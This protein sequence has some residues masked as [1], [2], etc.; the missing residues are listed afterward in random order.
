MKEGDASL[1]ESIA[2]E[3]KSLNQ[4]W[5]R[6]VVL[7]EEQNKRLTEL[8]D[9]SRQ[10]YDQIDGLT[11]WLEAIKDDLANKDYS[12]EN[13]NDLLVKNKKFKVCWKFYSPFYCC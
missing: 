10:V 1:Q 9:K 7:A 6:V 12:V 3:V 2:N 13:T 4:K 8:L 11:K 5:E